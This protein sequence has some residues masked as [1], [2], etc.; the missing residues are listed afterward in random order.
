M[1]LIIIEIKGP[2]QRKKNNNNTN[3]ISNTPVIP[4]LVFY[5]P[6]PALYAL[7][8]DVLQKNSRFRFPPLVL[9]GNW[10]VG[11]ICS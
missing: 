5:I 9:F 10:F 2:L 8:V 1:F 11:S 6:F 3:N 4:S 7:D